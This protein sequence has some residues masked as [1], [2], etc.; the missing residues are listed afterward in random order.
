MAANLLIIG[1]VA[2]DS[3]KTP[4][5]TRE[6]TLGGSGTYASFSA[7]F[8]TPVNLVSVVGEDFEKTNLE[9]LAA[10]KIDVAGIKV[11]KG[12]K[13]FFW[14]GFYEGDMNQANTLKTDLNVLLEFDPELPEKYKNSEYVFLANIDPDLQLKVLPQIKKPKLIAM[15]TMNFWITSKKEAL[16]KTI[17]QCDV[18]LINDAELKQLTG[19]QNVIKGARQLISHGC[20]NIII[21]KGEHGALLV[22]PDDTFFATAY[23]L[24][25]VKDPTG[26][27]DSFAGGFMSWLVKT[28]DLSP[29][30]LRRAV[31][32]GSVMASFNIEEFSCE[33]FKS[34]QESEITA[35]RDR[36]KELISF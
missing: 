27:G 32:H 18:L 3:V 12:G 8:L 13:T 11:I 29:A 14:Q 23:P 20:K 31:V 2:Y 22:S 1:T 28:D 5:G 24:E 33:R 15:D 9:L 16:L 6:K 17:S 30:N 34:L 10:R 36:F 26:A 4:Y 19:E 35:R 21:K 25:I 7:S